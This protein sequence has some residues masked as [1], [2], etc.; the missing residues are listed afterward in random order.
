MVAEFILMSKDMNVIIHYSEI[1]LKGKNRAFFE[2]KLAHNIKT[3]TMGIKKVFRLNGKIT[4]ELDD[5]C[6]EERI[7]KSLSLIPGV[8]SFA[9]AE[10]AELFLEAIGKKALEILSEE[11][12]KTFRITAVRSNKSFLKNSGE[13]NIRIGDIIRKK[14]NKK[15]NLDNPEVT[16]YIEISE[17]EVFLYTQKNRGI[18]GLPVGSSGKAVALLSGG[19]DSPAASFLAAKR[20]LKVVFCHVQ[21]KTMAGTREGVSKITKIAKGLAKIQGKSTLYIVPFEEI[22]KSIIT[23]IPAE[24][25]MIVYRRFMMRIAQSVAAIEK[26]KGIVTGDSIGQVASQ[27]LENLNCIYEGLKLPVFPPLIGMNKE[28]IIEIARKINTYD[29]SILPYPDCCSFLIAKHP[30]TKAD[31][32]KIAEFEKIIENK[33]KLV[34]KSV[35]KAIIKHITQ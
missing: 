6:R 11:K 24:L 1:G 8:S 32:R 27:T 19:I 28:E 21:N 4:A 26:A 16:L 14:L 23:C 33:N 18:G 9:F 22:Q 3:E 31:M 10:K 30:E 35:A 20:G 29:L 13:I 12:F 15:V 2:K 7:A 17:K 5:N 25:R 34:K